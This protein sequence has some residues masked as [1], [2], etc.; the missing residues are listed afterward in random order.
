[1]HQSDHRYIGVTRLAEPKEN[2]SWSISARLRLPGLLPVSLWHPFHDQFEGVKTARSSGLEGGARHLVQL[3][4]VTGRSLI[5]CRTSRCRCST[6]STEAPSTWEHLNA[7][8]WSNHRVILTLLAAKDDDPLKI[9]KVT[10][11]PDHPTRGQTVVAKVDYY[12]SM[13][14]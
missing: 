13:W 9:L 3:L 2:G 7:A 4:W 5:K 10:L 11:S 1:M 12:L 6:A 8:S 14:G